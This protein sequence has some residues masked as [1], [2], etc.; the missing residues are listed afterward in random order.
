MNRPVQITF[1]GMGSSE[2]MTE[3]IRAEAEKLEQF[4]DR[5][6]GCHVVVEQPHKHHHQG[7]LFHVRVDLHVPGKEIVAGRE[8]AD[9]HTHEDPY[10]AVN[11]AF[12]AVR[13]QLQHYA[14]VQHSHR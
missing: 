3:Y 10:R 7:N 4:C 12:E 5:I 14:E 11:D 6:V 13:H 9:R 2:A 1:R 8:H